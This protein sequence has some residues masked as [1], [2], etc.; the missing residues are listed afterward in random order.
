MAVDGPEN[1]GVR[2]GVRRSPR[3]PPRSRG[4][5]LHRGAPPRVPCR[6][7]GAGR[8]GDRSVVHVRRHERGSEIL[9]CPP[10]VRR[11]RRPARSLDRSGRRGREAVGADEGGRRGALRRVPGSRRP[12]R[13]AMRRG[14]SRPDRG[15]GPRSEREP[16]GPQARHVRPCRGVQPV[17]QQGAVG[18]G[19]RHGRHR[20][21]RGCRTRQAAAL[22]FDDVGYLGSPQQEN[23][24]VRRRGARVST[25]ASTSL[26]RRWPSRACR[27]SSAKSSCGGSSPDGTGA[28][29][30]M[31]RASRFRTPTRPSKPRPA[32]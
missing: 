18:R 7:R 14:R 17:L 12:S 13:A 15:R 20:R 2:A 5:Q 28:R 23:R 4:L 27:D 19:R 31:S 16:R 25:T 8:R 6:R 30:G 1:G 26:A 22:A 24:H 32:T 11:H 21:R 10:C 3:L 29:S 9:R